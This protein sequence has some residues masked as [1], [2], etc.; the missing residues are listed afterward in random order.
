MRNVQREKIPIVRPRW[1]LEKMERGI[2]LV[3]LEKTIRSSR[4]NFALEF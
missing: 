1:K 3:G 2:I 4:C